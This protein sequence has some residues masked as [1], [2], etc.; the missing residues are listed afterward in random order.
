MELELF[1]YTLEDLQWGERTALNRK[2]LSVSVADLQE[3]IKDIS[4][5]IQIDFELACPGESKRIVHVLDTVLPIAKLGRS[6]STFP[7]F[8]G[9]AQLV[10][11]GQTV[12]ISNLLVTIA[13]RFPHPEAMTPIEKPREGMID[14]AGVGAPYSYGSDYFQLILALTPDSSVSN[15]A[16]DQ[17]LRNIALRC[18]RFL[19]EVDKTGSEPERKIV[20]LRPVDE[21]LPKVVLIYQV[22]ASSLVRELFITA[23]MSPR[24]CRLLSTRR[25]SLTARW[26]AAITRASGRSPPPCTVP[27]RSSPSCWR[28]TA[29]L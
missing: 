12:R 10:G 3:Q 1:D 25:N 20:A 23:K 17:A 18:A 2:S 6:D 24:P 7:G 16:F 15:A 27:T 9:A 13:A 19:A 14:M 5:G 11:T 26:S 21:R 28:D 4:H 8:E 29:K 22:Q